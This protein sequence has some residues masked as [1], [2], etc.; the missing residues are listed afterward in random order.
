[1]GLRG[2][3][4]TK[5]KLTHIFVLKKAGATGRIGRLKKCIFNNEAEQNDV[6]LLKK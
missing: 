1:M 4:G 5:K 6:L 2:T 3:K